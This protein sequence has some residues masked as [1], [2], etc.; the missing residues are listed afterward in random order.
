MEN[1]PKQ[2]T[3]ATPDATPDPTE[4]TRNLTLIILKIR[5]D[6]RVMTREAR[7]LANWRPVSPDTENLTDFQRR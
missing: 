3:D 1:W 2:F 4:G 5:L 7:K 6:N